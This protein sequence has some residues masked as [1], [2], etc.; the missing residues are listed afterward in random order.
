[1]LSLSIFGGNRVDGSMLDPGEQL[2]VF[3]VFG[4]TEIDFANCPP[5]PGADVLIIS[6]FGGA[7]LYV[8]PE[9]PLRL[10]GFGIFGGRS[11]EPRRQ[12]PPPATIPPSSSGDDEPLDLPLEVASYAI[13]GGVSVK[14]ED[15][16]PVA[17]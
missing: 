6:I 5:P 9:Q 17:A 13:F 3:S 11:V 2:V 12:L 1:M 14:R 16:Q 4:G 10:T 8:R 7:E 15:P